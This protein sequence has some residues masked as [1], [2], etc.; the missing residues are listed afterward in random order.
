MGPWAAH[1]GRGMIRKATVLVVE[2][3][4]VD[5]RT[6]DRALRAA[7]SLDCQ[8]LRATSLREARE[9]ISLAR[10]DCILL[11]YHLPDGQGLD[12]LESLRL[13]DGTTICP[14]IMV[15]GHGN[16][17]VAV[18]AI[19]ADYVVKGRDA[20]AR[21]VEVVTR[22]VDRRKQLLNDGLRAH[23]TAQARVLEGRAK[24]APTATSSTSSPTS[25]ASW[26]STT[27]SGSGRSW[28]TTCPVSPSTAG[29]RSPS[30]GSR[31]APSPR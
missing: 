16:E 14:V 27:G 22:A 13:Q 15:T 29:S 9:H 21:I 28:W 18:A 30:A 25:C 24:P 4:E 26:T 1:A 10:P 8:V 23:M 19:K 3:D 11:D 31:R 5:L 17:T 7:P 20:P 2:D 6:V 12:L